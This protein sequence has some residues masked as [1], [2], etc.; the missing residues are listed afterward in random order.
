[1]KPPQRWLECGGNVTTAPPHASKKQ[2][3]KT[4]KPDIAA[5]IFD[6]SIFQG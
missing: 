3:A 5:A 1:M 4:R 2:K 6:R